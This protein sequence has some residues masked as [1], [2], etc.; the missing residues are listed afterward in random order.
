MRGR[1]PLTALLVLSV[2]GGCA[3]TDAAGGPT[4]P[5]AATPPAVIAT[6][7]PAP[8]R[9]P[10]HVAERSRAARGVPE[11]GAAALALQCDGVVFDGYA[12]NEIVDY[13][14]GAR[15]ADV[16]A[17][18]VSGDGPRTVPTHGYAH[19]RTSGKRALFTYAVAGR[20][21]VALIA[22]DRSGKGERGYRVGPWRGESW[23]QCDPAEFGV[24]ADGGHEI[25]LWSGPAG[26]RMAAAIVHSRAADGHCHPGAVFLRVGGS[27]HS[28]VRDPRRT[29][30]SAV[31][32]TS[33]DRTA[34]LPADAAD[35]GY[36][37]GTWR[38]WLPPDRRTAYVVTK[39]GVERWPAITR[40]SLC[41]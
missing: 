14:G 21:K 31:L 30:R 36:S 33:Y 26:A 17:G 32:S 41:A 7:A 35:T 3:G 5:R 23:A 34:A 24:E 13:P 2:L 6:A 18:F 28:F 10:L 39:D 20:R 9:G 27:S 4:A 22:V 8:Y 12:A 11:Y 38:L 16:L 25:E 37:R 19:V 1:T 15:P 40:T 29:F